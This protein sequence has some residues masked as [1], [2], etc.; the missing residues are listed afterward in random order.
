MGLATFVKVSGISNL[1]DARYCAGMGVNVLGFALE[2]EHPYYTDPEKYTAI[3]EWLAGVEFAAEFDTY[4]PEAIEKVLRTYSRIDYLQTS[5]TQHVA[6][7]ASL[8]KPL[9]VKLDASQYR[10]DVV[11]LADIMRDCRDQATY[12]LIE[13][14]AASPRTDLLNDLLHLSKQYPILLGFGLNPDNVSSLIREYPVA[15]LALRGGEE[16][17]PGYRNFDELANVLEAIEVE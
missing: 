14:S 4:S 6:A 9:I 12:F 3:T 7:L 2:Q 1:S 16:V 8:Q 13:N 11:A 17:R 15:G 10:E 5:Q